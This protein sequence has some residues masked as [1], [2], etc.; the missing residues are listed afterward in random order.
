MFPVKNIIFFLIDAV[1]ASAVGDEEI[2]I[3]EM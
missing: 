2:D 1:A 3:V